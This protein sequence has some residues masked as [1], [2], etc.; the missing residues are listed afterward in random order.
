MHGHRSHLG[1]IRFRVG[2]WRRSMTRLKGGRAM[3]K[4]SKKDKKG[5][6]NKK[7]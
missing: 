1:W 3:A 4:K 7:K 2:C 5:K 6:K